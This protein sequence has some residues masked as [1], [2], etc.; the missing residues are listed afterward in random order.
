MRAVSS[1]AQ[2]SRTLLSAARAVGNVVRAGQTIVL[3]STTFPGTTREYLLPLLEESGLRAGEDFALA[4]PR[5]EGSRR[6]GRR[7]RWRP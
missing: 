4:E 3:E 7:G 5:G 6:R 1:A 2:L